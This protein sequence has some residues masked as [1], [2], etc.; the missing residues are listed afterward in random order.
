MSDGSTY[1]AATGHD[2]NT[3]PDFR[4]LQEYCIR[5]VRD[6]P[7]WHLIETGGGQYDGSSFL[8]TLRAARETGTEIISDLMHYG[9]PDELDIWS[10][11]F[12]ERFGRFAANVVRIVKSETDKAQLLSNQ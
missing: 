11:T 9:W 1:L 8:L 7:R 3:S 2:L 12:P 6:G 4:Q 5:T 10:P